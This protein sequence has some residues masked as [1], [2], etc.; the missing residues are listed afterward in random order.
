M[1]MG[2]IA[3]LIDAREAEALAVKRRGMLS[4]SN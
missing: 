3:A 2:D 1:D 4:Y